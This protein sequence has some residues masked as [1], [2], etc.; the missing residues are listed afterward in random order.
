M[1]NGKGRNRFFSLPDKTAVNVQVESL[2]KEFELAEKSVVGE[3][4]ATH[5]NH[6]TTEYEKK[7]NIERIAPGEMLINYQ[8]QDCKFPLIERSIVD[9]LA[10][11]G[12]YTVYKQ[13]LQLKQLDTLTTIDES[14]SLEDVWSF[15]NHPRLANMNSHDSVEALLSPAN[16]G[17][18]GIV[19]ADKADARIKKRS[20][21]DKVS[22]PDE[23]LEEM[24]PFAEEYGLSASL[25]KAM[26]LNLGSNREYLL[27]RINELKPGQ[28]VW[29]AR[30]VHY[31]SRWGHF[32]TDSLQPVVITLF[33]DNELG[34]PVQS[35]QILKK[36]ELRRLARI[37]SEAYMQDGVFTTIDLDMLMNRSTPYISQLLDLYKKHYQM[38][39]PTAGTVLDAGRCLTHKREAIELALAGLNTKK[40]A[41]RLFHT[42]EAIDRYLDQF[43]KITLLN[44][45]YNVPQETI[46]YTLNC[47]N[48][49]VGEYL[50]IVKEHKEQLPDFETIERKFK[51]LN[52][53][54]HGA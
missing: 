44:Y 16:D 41:R 1:A 33:T 42:T 24:V 34:K 6:L 5:Y 28:A 12:E 8:G 52:N 31:K 37:T 20:I 19:R 10:Q 49:L 25:T 36:Q 40:I 51:E 54:H 18:P 9:E 30:S 21:P 48:S 13:K 26:L 4:I 39:L 7:E 17:K 23:V 3:A 22:P 14:A 32:I 27:P 38:W 53:L 47:G 35:R 50:D 45:K 29:L 2:K 11:T 46:A 15:I 43:E